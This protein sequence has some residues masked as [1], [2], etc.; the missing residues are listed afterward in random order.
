MALSVVRAAPTPPGSQPQTKDPDG[1]ASPSSSRTKRLVR[2][3]R[4]TSSIIPIRLPERGAALVAIVSVRICLALAPHLLLLP[5]HP[6]PLPSALLPNPFPFLS[7]SSLPP[8]QPSRKRE[9]KR[10]SS[11]HPLR[12]HRE[13]ALLF[14]LLLTAALTLLAAFLLAT[15]F[16][17]NDPRREPD[18]AIAEEEVE[19]ERI[20]EVDEVKLSERRAGVSAPEPEGWVEVEKAPAVVVK[21]EKVAECSP[22]PHEEEKEVPLKAAPAV[23]PGS[24]L[25]EETDV[26]EK[27]CDLTA[28]A[29]ATELVVEANPR[30]LVAEAVPRDVLDVTGLE[31]GPVQDVGAKEHDL[32][33]EAAPTAA[34]P[35]KQGVEIAVVFPT[36]LE[37]VE[38]E[39]Q[40]PV[41]EVSPSA[42]VVDTG[43]GESVAA[44]E[45]RPDE[46]A[47][48]TV[49]EEIPV[50]ALE[51]KE[52]QNV[53]AKDNE[54]TADVVPQA[55]LDVPLS[56]EEE[57]KAQQTV[58]E[59]VD[60]HEEVQSRE[61]AKCDT[62]PVDQQKQ[63]VPEVEPVA[64]KTG[65]AEVNCEGS[66]SDKVVTE[67][68][69]EVNH[70]G[71]SSD[72]VVTELPVEVVTL[73]G[74]PEDD[75][76]ADMDFG[77]WE[78]IE[79]SEVEKKFGA[80]AAFAASDA[81]AAALSKLNSD[82][83]LE[84]QGLLKVAIDGP[85]Y[86]ATQPLTL[87]PSSRAKWYSFL[88]LIPRL[89]LSLAYSVCG[90][91]YRKYK[92]KQDW[93]SSTLEDKT[94]AM[95]SSKQIQHSGLV[96]LESNKA[97]NP[98]N[99]GFVC[100]SLF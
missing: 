36:K 21:E 7:P 30:L 43:I 25:E 71:S 9:G 72:K 63:L 62:H 3:R 12:T 24:V 69:V 28:A 10:A 31:S 41:S 81:G 6:P 100:V 1:I 47:S 2:R 13:M 99:N 90:R 55:A 64:T 42:E 79:R 23:R 37:A 57:L 44:I 73:Q 48:E 39:Q 88:F 58:E 94:C 4:P 34:E 83:Q 93:M 40:H 32:G 17:A 56:E 68:P 45:V 19:E 60:A 74:P 51:E 96:V 97:T 82:V 8:A 61:E 14:E 54:S 80:A 16:A 75:A 70:E 89:H 26:G 77:E 11:S 5:P 76:E 18:R 35:E 38:A 87:R 67:L 86:D 29:A 91:S 49:S 65:A 95:V 46:L 84:L 53:E 59:A 22:E 15:F 52:E 33:A 27:R 92:Q 50:V 78:G 85:C 66:S 20:V 98:I